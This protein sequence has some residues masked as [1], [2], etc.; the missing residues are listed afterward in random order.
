MDISIIICTWNNCKQLVKTLESLSQC[1]I[2]KALEW[3]IIVVNNNCSD[4]TDKILDEFIH[5]LPLVYIKEPMQGLSRARNAGV[6]V[7]KGKLIIFTDDDVYHNNMWIMTYWNAYIEKPNGF[8]F[9]GP[10]ESKFESLD[11]D[12][13][14]LQFSPASIKGLYW[15]EKA[16][17]LSKDE[18][19]IAANWGCPAEAFKITG[20]FDVDKGLDSSSVIIKVGEESDLMNRLISRGYQPWYLPKAK[21][22]HFVP[23][24][25]CNL[26]HIGNRWFAGG[27]EETMHCSRNED[28]IYN[29]AVPR[30]MYRDL[31]SI[32]S[33][34]LFKKIVF[35]NAYREYLLYRRLQ[36]MIQ[37]YRDLTVQS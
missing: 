36:G 8:F 27:Y 25:K 14:L 1:T 34:W 9:G 13:E 24:S 16:R 26:K 37:G 20:A 12:K 28:N 19:F 3:E 35:N 32:W 18:Y 6:K 11:F 4:D 15:G 30:W 17:I 29:M 5:K 23:K 2:D 33:K 31:I 22:S 21:I 7:A 10:I